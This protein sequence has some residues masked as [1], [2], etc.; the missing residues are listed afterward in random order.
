MFALNQRSPDSPRVREQDRR[1][2]RLEQWQRRSS[3][4]RGGQSGRLV[5]LLRPGLLKMYQGA[6]PRSSLPA[7]D[8]VGRSCGRG[9]PRSRAIA[10]RVSAN[11][12]RDTATPAVAFCGST[13]EPARMPEEYDL[14]LLHPDDKLGRD[15]AITRTEIEELHRSSPGCQL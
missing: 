4:A 12:C 3:R 10:D 5:M 14:T 11:I 8:A 7:F 15:I 6:P 13:A 9:G 1:F 2:A